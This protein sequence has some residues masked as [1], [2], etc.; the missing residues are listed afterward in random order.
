MPV[1]FRK[2][3]F[4]PG[5]VTLVFGAGFVVNSLL[6]GTLDVLF[7]PGLIGVVLGMVELAWRYHQPMLT[8]SPWGITHRKTLYSGA[9]EYPRD[10]IV[11]WFETSTEVRI[12]LGG[13]KKPITIRLSELHKKDAPRLA[14]VLRDCGYAFSSAYD[15]SGGRLVFS[16]DPTR[17][18]PM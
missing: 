15:G 16:K 1:H 10:A 17:P 8:V 14:G 4:G 3:V 12:N 5:L 2:K 9:R 18:E 11:S 7:L 6:T 13:G